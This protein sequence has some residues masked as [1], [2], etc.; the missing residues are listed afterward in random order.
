[1]VKHSTLN[2]LLLLAGLYVFYKL[3][4]KRCDNLYEGQINDKC[5]EF[6]ENDG[7]VEECGGLDDLGKVA[8]CLKCF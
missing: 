8:D 3:H 7:T 2:I 4:N 6:T 1:M 5:N